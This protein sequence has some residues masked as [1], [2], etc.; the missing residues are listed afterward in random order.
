[1]RPDLEWHLAERGSQR[2]IQHYV[3]YAPEVLQDRIVSHVPTLPSHARSPLTWMSPLKAIWLVEFRDRAFLEALGLGSHAAALKTF[4]PD[5]GP[6]WDAL[7]VGSSSSELSGRIFLLVEAK[8][9]RASTAASG[10]HRLKSALSNKPHLKRE[11][12]SD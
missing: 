1:M 10:W 9:H 6:C 8:S 3:N 12:S 2:Q 5:G 11:L 4:W 7:A